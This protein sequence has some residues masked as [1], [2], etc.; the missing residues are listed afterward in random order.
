[1]KEIF[2]LIGAVIFSLGGAG[3]IIFALS[4]W[5]GKVWAN[6]ILE[7]EK[8]KHQLEI[9]EYKSKL[10][11]ELNKVNSLNQKALYITKVQYNK[12]FGI[13]QDIWEKLFDCIVATIN[14]YP[15]FDEV[16]T[17][18]DE[19]Q[20][21]IDKKY[22]NYR[23]KYNLY[24]RTIDRYAPFYE[25]NFYHSFVEVRKNCSKMGTIFKRYNYDVKYNMTYAI[26]RDVSM[27]E[28]EHEEVYDNIPKALEEKRNKLQC[29]IH[30]YL[31]KLQ[32]VQS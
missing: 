20:K 14:L 12:E 27:T 23:D 3:A 24:S 13:Y 18:E 29:N 4:S 16:P 31:K 25:E 28:K 26:V 1:M 2:Q 7:E 8:K 5:L 19:K 15:S 11:L 22:E 21:W 10:M 9:E 30:E 32:V 17:D 6:R